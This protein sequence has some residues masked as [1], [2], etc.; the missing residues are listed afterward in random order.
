[1]NY[2][3]GNLYVSKEKYPSSIIDEMKNKLVVNDYDY[4]SR[5]WNKINYFYETDK[6]LVAPKYYN[7]VETVPHIPVDNAYCTEGDKIEIEMTKFPDPRDP[8]Q[9]KA[10]DFILNNDAGIIKAYTGFGKTWCAIRAITKYKKKT[11]IIVGRKKLRD[12]WIDEI[13]R[14]TDLEK[15]DIGILSGRSTVKKA[16][17]KPVILATINTLASISKDGI[18]PEENEY[19]EKFVEANIGLTILDEVHKTSTTPYFSYGSLLFISKKVFGLSATP[20]KSNSDLT[21]IMM[22]YFNNNMFIPDDSNRV[23]PSVTIIFYNSNIPFKTW[24]FIKFSGRLDGVRYR[25]SLIK[26]SEVYNKLIIKLLSTINAIPKTSGILCAGHEIN[27][28]QQIQEKLSNEIEDE[29]G[30]IYAD[31]ED[32]EKE[33]KIILA[34]FQSV[35]EGLSINHLNKLVIG[36][37]FASETSV[38]QIA[39]RITRDHNNKDTD[40]EIFDLVDISDPKFFDYLEKRVSVYNALKLKING[41]LLYQFNDDKF[42][43]V[44]KPLNSILENK[45]I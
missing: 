27:F 1:M 21:K 12:Q 13:T 29:I 39:G 36:T 28:L 35:I 41:L 33:K 16:L 5:T 43:L 25:K 17:N 38:E 8:E 4:F 19:F 10:V 31:S 37:P 3:Y 15:D 26:H 45:R 18:T 7:S 14:F 42:T 9:Q 32:G 34:T 40:P 2:T 11:M 22:M 30:L 23:K 6:Y 20:K 44:D 24:K